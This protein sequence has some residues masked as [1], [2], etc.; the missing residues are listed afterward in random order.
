MKLKKINKK[1]SYPIQPGTNPR[2]HIRSSLERIQEHVSDP[3]IESKTR[4][5]IQHSGIEFFT[6]GIRSGFLRN[7]SHGCSESWLQRECVCS[8][9]RWEG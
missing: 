8:G 2:A 9:E 7:N 6:H 1:K 3:T 5:P 4:Y